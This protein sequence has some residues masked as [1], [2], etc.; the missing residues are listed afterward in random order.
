MVLQSC[1]RVC[2]RLFLK[3]NPSLSRGVF[4]FKKRQG[5]VGLRPRAAA[6]FAERIGISMRAVR[7]F[8]WKKRRRCRFVTVLFFFKKTDA[9]TTLG[10]RPFVGPSHS[11]GRKRPC[12][13]PCGLVPPCSTCLTDIA[14]AG[15]APRHFAGTFRNRAAVATICA[16]SKANLAS[17]SHR[18]L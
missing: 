2:R 15:W 9:S 4:C 6:G 12:S 13:R 10:P 18:A 8:F 1:G 16:S 11:Y 7:L 3:K 5:A 17:A 14:D